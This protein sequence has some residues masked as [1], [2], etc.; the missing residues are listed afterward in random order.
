[1]VKGATVKVLRGKKVPVGTTGV[2]FWTQDG[3]WGL[4]LGLKDAAGTVHWVAAKN[5]VVVDALEPVVAPKLPF[6]VEAAPQDDRIGLL[7]ARILR[8]E[9]LLSAGAT[10]TPMAA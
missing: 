1:M 5:C 6:A 10:A 9:L 4:R 8:L 2:V 3:Q 7:E